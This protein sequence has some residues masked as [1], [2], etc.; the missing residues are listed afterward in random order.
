M[1]QTPNKKLA[2]KLFILKL[3]S[4]ENYLIGLITSEQDK[5]GNIFEVGEGN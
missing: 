2:M 3:Q 5:V 1:T 4:V